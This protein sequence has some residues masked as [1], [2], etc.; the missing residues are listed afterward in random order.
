MT[1]QVLYFNILLKW[2]FLILNTHL[3]VNIFWLVSD[4]TRLQISFSCNKTNSV[5]IT[6]FHFSQLLDFFVC[7]KLISLYELMT[8][9]SAASVVSTHIMCLWLC[10]DESV[11]MFATYDSFFFLSF[12]N[13]SLSNNLSFFK[14][15]SDLQELVFTIDDMSWVSF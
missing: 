14:N 2:S 9:L 15:L 8:S 13:V 4:L 10:E 7:F 6:V 3:S 12:A 5:F 11:Y 1:Y